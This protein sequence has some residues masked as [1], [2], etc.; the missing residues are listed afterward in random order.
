MTKEENGTWNGSL[1]FPQN[2]TLYAD[3]FTERNHNHEEFHAVSLESVFTHFKP[4]KSIELH[5]ENGELV[6]ETLSFNDIEDFEDAQLIEQC[7]LLRTDHRKIEA[8]N[9]IIRQL[10]RNKVLRQALDDAT[11]RKCW[12][13]FL[14][15]TL[16]ELEGQKHQNEAEGAEDMVKFGDFQLLKNIVPGIENMDP[17]RKAAKAIFLTDG[18]FLHARK[19]LGDE[20][21]LWIALL[22]NGEIAPAELINMCMSLRIQAEERLQDNLSVIRREINQLEVTYRTLETFFD[23]AR[24]GDVN[25]LTLINLSKDLLVSSESNALEPIENELKKYYDALSLKNSYSLLVVPG[26]LGDAANLRK[27]AD[28][29][30][31]N[32]V[33]LVTDFKDCR[34]FKLLKEELEETHLQGSE[35]MLSSMI[36]TCN[37]ILGRKKSELSDEDDDVYIPGSGALAGRLSNIEE[38]SIAQGVVG[39]DH[40]LLNHVKGTRLNLLVSEIAVL[41]AHGVIPLIEDNGQTFALSNRSLYNGASVSLQEYPIVRVLDWVNKVL[42]NYMHDIALETWD[43]Y[44]SP[45]KLEKK[46]RD[47]LDHCRSYQLL[48]SNYK[49]AQPKQDPKTKVVTVDV[50][51]TPFYSTKNLIIT[52]EADNKE[53]LNAN[54]AVE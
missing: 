27:W 32:K 39:R 52:L 28:L 29:A 24:E 47:F 54:T 40:G 30:Y 44:V 41:V 14:E 43:P 36:M 16:A 53:Y 48:F 12:K 42:M 23:N 4:S 6:E 9:R 13:D 45:Q 38:T 31:R 2:R 51:V 15:T 21:K 11:T 37:Y 10:E 25:C 33:L 19:K 35:V 18:A 5:N 8:Y 17:D 20:L 1:E 22:A 50:S 49:L 46:I 34:S 3:Q 26:H 7:E